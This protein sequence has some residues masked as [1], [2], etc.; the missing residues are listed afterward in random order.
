MHA[1]K[2]SRT[3][4]SLTLLMVAG[5]PSGDARGEE[6]DREQDNDNAN[7]RVRNPESFAARAQAAARLFPLQSQA[8]LTKNWLDHLTQ[9]EMP[10]LSSVPE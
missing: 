10:G 4:R 3:G 1:S 8:A 6:C 7:E 2:P 5:E 9:V